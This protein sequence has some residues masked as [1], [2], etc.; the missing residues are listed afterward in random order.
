M[1]NQQIKALQSIGKGIIES[2][3]IDSI[4]APS[5]VIYAALMAHGASLNQFQSIMNTLVRSGFL[6]HDTDCQTYHATDSG[7]AWSNK[8]N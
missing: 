3:N 7:I 5:S 4:G 6:T 8:I 2:C 1:T